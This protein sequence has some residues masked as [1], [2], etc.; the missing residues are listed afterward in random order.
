[1][2]S[3]TVLTVVTRRICPTCVVLDLISRC[4]VATTLARW[5]LQFGAAALDGPI[6]LRLV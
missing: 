6:C 2:P 1:M 4:A 5:W 3:K